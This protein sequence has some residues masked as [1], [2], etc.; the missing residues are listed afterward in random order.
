MDGWCAT[1]E[2]EGRVFRPQR[3]HSLRRRYFD[4]RDEEGQTVAELHIHVALHYMTPEITPAAKPL[5]PSI[6]MAPPAKL[7]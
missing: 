5:K 7:N 3:R 6:G 1:D 2:L 4:V